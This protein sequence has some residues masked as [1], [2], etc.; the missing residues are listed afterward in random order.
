MENSFILPGWAVFLNISMNTNDLIASGN[1]ARE[2]HNP[3]KAIA[4]YAQAFVQDPDH[5]GALHNV[6]FLF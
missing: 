4:F 3:E 6:L 5:S 1:L 2:Q